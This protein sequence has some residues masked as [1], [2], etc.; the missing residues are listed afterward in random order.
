MVSAPAAA[1][2]RRVK[3]LFWLLLEKAGVPA[4]AAYAD[5]AALVRTLTALQASDLPHP[6]LMDAEPLAMTLQEASSWVWAAGGDF[7]SPDGKRVTFTSP[8]ALA[9]FR[10]YFSLRRFM[11]AA[12]LQPASFELFHDRAAA[13]VVDSQWLA[14][15]GRGS[16]FPQFDRVGIATFAPTPYVGGSSLVR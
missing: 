5:H 15:L 3:V 9:G 16:N 8:E 13:V 7:I 1:P 6:L 12:T 4:A 14:M 10:N 11:P 2:P